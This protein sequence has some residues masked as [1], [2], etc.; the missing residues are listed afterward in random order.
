MG[1]INFLYI[2]YGIYYML[3]VGAGFEHGLAT[4]LTLFIPGHQ[5]GA[6]EPRNNSQ[7]ALGGAD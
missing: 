3:A 4:L 7:S 2:F 6:S 5:G 1:D